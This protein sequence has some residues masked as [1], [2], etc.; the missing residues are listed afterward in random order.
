MPDIAVLLL[1]FAA[2]ILILVAEIFIPS[3]GVLTLVS[4]LFLGMGVTQTFA[5]YGR[6]A[7]L[8]SLIGCAITV[9]GILMLA[10]RYGRQTWIGR[11][12]APPNPVLSDDDTS[13]PN[14]SMSALIGKAGRSLSPLRP[15]GI[16][17]FEGRRISCIAKFGTIDS[18]VEVEG[19]GVEGGNL[20]VEPRIAEPGRVDHA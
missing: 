3:Q 5:G 19:V 14:R 1:L 11:K 18:D 20:E 8:L 16:C 6:D 13:V 10:I 2:G 4:L 9:P 7:G 17:I 15:V 12:I